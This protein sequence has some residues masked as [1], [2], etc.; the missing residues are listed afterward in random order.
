MEISS[1]FVFHRFDTEVKVN[2]DG[3]VTGNK[4]IRL[5]GPGVC[6]GYDGMG[7]VQ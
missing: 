7:G 2:I 4:R 1:N 3:A 5:K 6:G